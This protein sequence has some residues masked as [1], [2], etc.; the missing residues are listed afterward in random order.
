MTKH[1]LDHETTPHED[2]RTKPYAKIARE[3]G[4]AGSHPS[5]KAVMKRPREEDRASDLA[6]IRKGAAHEN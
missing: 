3:T 1:P 6:R 4:P 2:S 5:V